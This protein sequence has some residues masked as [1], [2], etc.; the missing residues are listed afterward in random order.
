MFGW[1]SVGGAGRLRS[2]VGQSSPSVLLAEEDHF[3]LEQGLVDRWTGR[4]EVA[5]EPYAVNAGTDVGAQFHHVEEFSHRS[6][7][8]RDG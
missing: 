4:I 7:P 1:A 6:I 2:R 5:G 8:T 3:V